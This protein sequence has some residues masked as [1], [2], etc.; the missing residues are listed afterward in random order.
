MVICSA[1]YA[2]SAVTCQKPCECMDRATADANWGPNGYTLC[3]KNPCGYSKDMKGNPVE[4]FCIQPIEKPVVIATTP[5]TV[6]CQTPC[7]CKDQATADATWGPD[8]Y[9]LCS[10]LPC[11]YSKDMK[12]NPVEQFCVQP[13]EA[14]AVIATTPETVTC[15]KP[16]GC[17]DRP[18]ADAK[19]GPDGYS[20]CSKLPCGFSKDMK[21][22]PVD[23]FCIQPVAVPVMTTTA[24]IPIDRFVV[25][26]TYIITPTTVSPVASVNR[27]MLTADTDRDGIPDYRDNCPGLYN[28]SQADPDG[29]GLGTYCDVCTYVYNPDQTDTD[30]D[31]AGD[32]CDD[33]PYV[34]NVDHH[35][36]D[37][38]G[39]G[40]ACQ[41]PCSMNADNVTWFS[42]TW[43]RER[44]WMTSVKDQ[45]VCGSCYAESPVGAMEAKYNIEQGHQ[46]NLDLS[47]QMF[48][49]PCS[50][51]GNVGSCLGGWRN[52]V[53]SHLKNDGVT[54]DA[55]FPY[56][57]T[58]CVH[59]EPNA[60]D[61][62]KSHDVCNIG[63]NT[64]GHCSN[65]TTCPRCSDWSSRRWKITTYAASSGSV[66]SVKQAVLCN[67]PL[68]VCSGHWWHCVVMVGWDDNIDGGSWIIK[69]SWGAG[70]NDQGYGTIPFNGSDYSE[71]RN[72]AWYVGGIYHA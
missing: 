34:Y 15:Q 37:H 56:R 7:Q 52:E 18:T 41:D 4:Q 46:T 58:D 11:G 10:K 68:S 44:N 26:V 40:D 45:V 43:W 49:S 54:D 35:D 29:D 67:G 24:I 53:L 70:W 28:P 13:V 14:P 65:P 62:T 57:S 12:G 50:G 33:C 64:T 5:E 6:T 27:S 36:S 25:P 47:E 69:N 48:V 8:G 63:C 20:L 19:W 3:E 31:M 17:M 42:W 39:I 21:G 59:S 9:S 2:A 32:A 30:H 61:P 71:I 72:D 38:N 1:A 22:N 55:C 23:Q 51:I 66:K 16:C 60:D